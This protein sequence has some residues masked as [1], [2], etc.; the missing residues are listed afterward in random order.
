MTVSPFRED[1][2]RI[3]FSS[4]SDQPFAL[5]SGC[6]GHGGLEGPGLKDARSVSLAH[7]PCAFASRRRRSKSSCWPSPVVVKLTAQDFVAVLG[8]VFS[9]LW[10]LRARSATARLRDLSSR[11]CASKRAVEGSIEVCWPITARPHNH[12]KSLRTRASTHDPLTDQ[13]V[14]L[15]SLLVIE[16][17][18]GHKPPTPYG[19]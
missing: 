5:E 6:S 13:Q 2:R 1:D 10:P 15:S 7:G 14:V 17:E 12:K 3:F 9:R 4:F 19:A 8:L 18:W 11:S 16:A